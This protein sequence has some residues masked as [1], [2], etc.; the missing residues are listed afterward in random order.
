MNAIAAR[1][2]SRGGPVYPALMRIFPGFIAAA[3]FFGA[4]G[5]AAADTVT[6][7]EVRGLQ[8]DLEANLRRRL[9]LAKLLGRELGEQRLD[10]LL[11][12]S[13]REARQALEPYGYFSSR[14][15]PA[16]RARC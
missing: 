8:P 11:L 2:T 12:E 13:E 1:R 16:V 15:R 5:G 9:S 6:S 14:R 3:V 7:I 10:Y 4:A